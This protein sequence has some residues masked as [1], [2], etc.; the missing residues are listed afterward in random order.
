MATP[1]FMMDLHP[2]KL[3]EDHVFRHFDET[4]PRNLLSS[5]SIRRENIEKLWAHQNALVTLKLI[6]NY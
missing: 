6:S 5:Q 3:T 2:S 1:L 4:D